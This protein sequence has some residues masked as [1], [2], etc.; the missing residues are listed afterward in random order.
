MKKNKICINYKLANVFGLDEA[1][2]ITRF[3]VHQKKYPD[4]VDDDNTGWITKTSDEWIK[5]YFVFWDRVHVRSVFERLKKSKVLITK[6]ISDKKQKY[7]VDLNLISER[8]RAHAQSSIIYNKWISS[9]S[10][11]N[12]IYNN[13]NTTTTTTILDNSNTREQWDNLDYTMLDCIGFGKSD[14]LNIIRISKITPEVFVTSMHNFVHDFKNNLLNEKTK[15]N[16]L[17]SFVSILISCG[18]YNSPGRRSLGDESGSSAI[19]HVDGCRPVVGPLVDP[20]DPV[21]DELTNNPA[22]AYEYIRDVWRQ[23][24]CDIFSAKNPFL[25]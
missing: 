18:S 25:I 8:M 15:K 20:G 10:I 24:G 5:F 3:V 22:K 9:S 7:R 21:D 19:S 17:R 14:L 12:N 11:N 2:M 13:N 16:P 1:L 6:K 4:I 23:I